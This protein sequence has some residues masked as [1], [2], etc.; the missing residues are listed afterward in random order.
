MNDKQ[1][2]DKIIKKKISSKNLFFAILINLF[3]FVS[4]FLVYISYYKSNNKKLFNENITNVNSLNLASAKAAITYTNDIQ[5]KLDD[6]VNFLTINS[7]SVNQT[8]DYLN[9]SN[10]NPSRQMQLVLCG[11]YGATNELSFGDYSGYSIRK[12]IDSNKNLVGWTPLS[13]R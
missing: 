10:T 1:K 5:N 8:I 7:Y 2:V 12:Y 11:S 9:N 13:R 3:F 4:I 6:I